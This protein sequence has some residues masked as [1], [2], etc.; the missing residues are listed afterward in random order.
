MDK[1]I[2]GVFGATGCNNF[3]DYGIWINDIRTFYN[4][5]PNIKIKLFS[6][7]IE[8]TLFYIEKNLYDIAGKLEIEVVDDITNL[9]K[10]KNFWENIWN[11]TYSGKVSSLDSNFVKNLNSCDKIIFVG[12]GYLNNNWKYRNL[13]FMSIVNCC[14]VLNK[15]VYFLANTIGPLDDE[16]RY[17]ISRSLKF[18]KSIMIRDNSIFSEKVL[19]SMGYENIIKG[20]DDFMFVSKNNNTQIYSNNSNYVVI[21]LMLWIRKAKKGVLYTIN[22]IAKF[23]NYIIEHENKNIVLI[24]FYKGDFD[25]DRFLNILY[26]SISNKDKVVI[27]KDISNIYRINDLYQK[28]DFSLSLR[29]HPLLIALGNKKPCLGIITDK[30]GYYYSKFGGA[31]SN[32]DLDIDKYTMHI[33]DLTYEALLSKYNVINEDFKIN[34]SKY[35][36]LYN[37]RINYIK[38]ILK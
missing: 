18:V 19:L 26:S 32:L 15:P 29:Y 36:Q 5:N 24:N 28:C 4:L 31:I 38:Q 1:Q 11:E 2:L 25:T 9:S 17:K 21:E 23:S 34:E 37:V 7:N 35:N 27:E 33:D 30:D 20:P 13:I 16:Y 14:K 6:Y 8:T 10:D 3:G 12:G 22:E